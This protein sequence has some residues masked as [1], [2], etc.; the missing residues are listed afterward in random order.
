MF[1]RLSR[2][3]HGADIRFS[4]FLAPVLGM[5]RAGAE[6][7]NVGAMLKKACADVAIDGH[8]F[9]IPGFDPGDVGSARGTLCPIGGAGA[10]V[11]RLCAVADF[12]FDI[13]TPTALLSGLKGIGFALGN[14]R[15][16]F[17]KVMILSKSR[18]RLGLN[19]LGK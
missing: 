19:R 13:H 18:L 5:F 15:L 11:G 14:S 12:G 8:G 9:I 16:K 7:G 4:G 3:A 6:V 17:S 10:E 2:P 1:D